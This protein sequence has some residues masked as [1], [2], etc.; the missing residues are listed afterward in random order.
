[1]L[2]DESGRMTPKLGSQKWLNKAN[3]ESEGG[4][5]FIRSTIPAHW[6]AAYSSALLTRRYACITTGEAAVRRDWRGE[7]YKRSAK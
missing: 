1:M 6:E 3:L 5:P 7:A 2:N 4:E